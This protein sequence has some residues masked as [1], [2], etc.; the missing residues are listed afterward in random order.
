MHGQTVVIPDI[1]VD[2]RIPQEA[3]RPTFV[4]SLVMVPI[5][6]DHAVGAIGAYWGHLHRASGDEVATLESLAAASGRA[7]KRILA[8]SDCATGL[9]QTGVL[10]G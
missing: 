10:A 4:R 7:L 1:R 3:Y 5:T 9:R 8:S 2:D 6:M